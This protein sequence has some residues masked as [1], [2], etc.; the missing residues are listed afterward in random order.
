MRLVNGLF[1]AKILYENGE[2][3][4]RDEEK[5]HFIVIWKSLRNDIGKRKFIMHNGDNFMYLYAG[6][7]TNSR[8]FSRRKIYLESI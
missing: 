8:N 5:N 4:F 6:S 2:I 1:R 3:G 7:P